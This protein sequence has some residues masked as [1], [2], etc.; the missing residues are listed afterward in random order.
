MLAQDSVELLV[1][2]GLHSTAKQFGVAWFS[3]KTPSGLRSLCGCERALQRLL[4]K[5]LAFQTA[6]RRMSL[7]TIPACA[8]HLMKTW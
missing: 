8:E 2:N 6:L 1:V 3:S 4:S 5:Y 7:L